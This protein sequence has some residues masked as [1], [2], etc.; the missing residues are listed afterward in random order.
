[1]NFGVAG[2]LSFVRTVLLSCTQGYVNAK[3]SADNFFME[4]SVGKRFSTD[5]LYSLTFVR[6]RAV[7]YGRFLILLVDF[8]RFEAQL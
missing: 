1:M 6:W 7:F 3:G 2:S 4:M 5:K 8:C